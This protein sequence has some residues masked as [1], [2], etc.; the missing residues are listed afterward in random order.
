MWSQSILPI[1]GRH[2][3]L[4]AVCVMGATLPMSF[5]GP[6]VAMP[7]IGRELGGGAAA[8][9]WAMS[10][11][12]LNFGS[13]VMAAGT[14]ADRF[15]RRRLFVVGLTTFIVVSLLLGWAPNLATLI[16]LR[17]LQGVSAALTGSAGA[18]A[19]AQEFE[20]SART[21]A[22]ALLGASFGVGLAIGPVV[23]GYL[24]EI[25]GWRTVFLLSAILGL[26]ALLL[27]GMSMRE[28]R[29]PEAT[30]LDLAGIA[31]FSSA[32]ALLSAALTESARVGWTGVPLLALGGS[33]VMLAVFIAVERH[34][35]HPM[36]DLTL[37]RSRHFL[38][39]QALPLATAFGFVAP[40]VMLP[41][42]LVGVE[43]YGETEAGLMMLPLSVPIAIVPLLAAALTRWMSAGAVSG[44]GLLVAAGGLIALGRVPAG[45]EPASFVGP[46]LA[47]GIGTGL[48]W[49]L[50]DSLAMSVAP[51]ERAGMA[52]G[53]FATVRVAGEA[54]ALAACAAAFAALL[55]AKLHTLLS[56]AT[57]DPAAL[58]SALAAGQAES[59]IRALPAETASRVLPAY[60]E[61]FRVL[62][63]GLAAIAAAGG[64][65]AFAWLSND[66]CVDRSG[67][68][69][70][71][72]RGGSLKLSQKPMRCLA[73]SNR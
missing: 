4:A 16:A 58:V 11:F 38:G 20:G 28:S 56:P 70:H 23:C 68:Q 10:V 21:R 65:C 53:I 66:T 14:L 42:R 12:V 8:L 41:V 37:F 33:A 2:A 39:V 31:T 29:D 6:A 30:R 59:A 43:H 48:P 3:V 72:S 26:T 18:A 49:G 5:T 27:G 57:I 61:A 1:S 60:S 47:I 34:C 32:L 54:I 55:H 71:H 51:K 67:E 63:Y 52:T 46:L 19:L 40:L 73:N 44:V 35:K 62:C 24:V 13:F 64:L 36:L 50:M 25:W 22:Y 9:S 69:D 17:A 7:A 15:G 45:S